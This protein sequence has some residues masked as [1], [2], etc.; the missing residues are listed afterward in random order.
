MTEILENQLYLGD[1]NDANDTSFLIDNNINTIICVAKDGEIKVDD[2]NKKI[3]IHYF[4]IEDNLT[5]NIYDDFDNITKLINESEDRS[6]AILI[7]CICGISRS[8]TIVTAYLMK[9]YKMSLNNSLKGIYNTRR[10]ICINSS[11]IEQLI[12][13]EYLI[14]GRNSISFDDCHKIFFY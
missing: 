8:A 12:K 13:Y 11:F 2:L 1:I 5:Y 14:Y 3:N 4:D 7:N 10:E 9:Y 6:G